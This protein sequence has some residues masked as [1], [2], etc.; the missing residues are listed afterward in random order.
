MNVIIEAIKYPNEDK[1]VIHLI[2]KLNESLISISGDDGTKR[3]NLDDFNQE[4]AFFVIALNDKKAIAC[5][6]F[7]P[8]SAQ[9]CEIKR[10]FS[11]EKSKGIGGKIL[12]SLEKAA[13]QLGYQY[14]YL[15]TRKNN[16]NAIKF[17]L[18]N[19]YNIIENYG[20]YI[21]R[22][23]AICFGKELKYL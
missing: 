20:V 15:E 21:G 6:G 1:R 3:A 8:L 19:G 11:L 13:K 7:R 10:M 14:I 18:K 2:D 16:K 5:G 23:E 12:L 4:K 22:L 9:I 17:Y